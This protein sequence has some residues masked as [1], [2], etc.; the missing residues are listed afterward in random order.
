MEFRFTQPV[1]IG[2][3][4]PSFAFGLLAISALFC[5]CASEPQPAEALLPGALRVA[6]QR[7]ATEL[8]C[9]SATAQ[10]T[11]KETIQE[12]QGTGWYESPHR[13]EYTVAVSGCGKHATYAVACDDRQKDCVAGPVRT[14]GPPPQPL[15]DKMQPEA[16]KAAQQRGASEFS[17]P[18]SATDVLDKET[19]QEPQGTGWYEPPHRAQY[20]VSI[21]GC[22][23]RT[24]YTVACDDRQTG[25]TVAPVAAAAPPPQLLADRMQP[26]A[27]QAAQRRGA[28]AVNC[29][30]VTTEVLSAQTIEE[31][32]TTGWYEPPH[33]AEYTIAVS[34]CGKRATYSVACD[35]RTK[36]GCV[37][38]TAENTSR[39]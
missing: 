15:A 37:A 20:T 31:P 38:G 22:G 21:S 12:P 36:K 9:Q 35:D 34:G 33:R 10:V 23:K 11:N 27:V 28:F 32:Q 13:A 19:I 5:G 26:Q 24:N 17:C 2:I 16:V 30:S 3:T 39:D 6:Q 29:V 8:G 4:T 14:A 18:E 7:G 25:C 1:P